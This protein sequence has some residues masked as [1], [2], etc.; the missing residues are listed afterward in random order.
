MRSLPVPIETTALRRTRQNH[1]G[2]PW[3]RLEGA[4]KRELKLVLLEN[5]Q[6][7]CA[8][9]EVTIG[10]DNSH[11]DHIRTRNTSPQL[12]FAVDNL[13]AACQNPRT[14]GHG[15]QNKGSLPPWVHPYETEDLEDRID[16]YP[17]GSLVPASILSEATQ[18]EADEAI[19][20]Q[21][22]LNADTLKE[23]RERR[24]VEIGTY[25]GQG[26]TVED[27][28]EILPDFPTLTKKLC[29]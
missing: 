23:R 10:A 12:I 5:Q 4:S 11:L 20:R 26:F 19:N 22:N 16:Y 14:C 28:M 27:L 13:L 15:R 3:E 9:C 24:M 6:N 21:L 1:P 18:R 29:R 7:V 17:D 8:W 25:C 2:G